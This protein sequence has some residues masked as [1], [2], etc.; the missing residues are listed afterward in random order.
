[1]PFW[2]MITSDFE[3]KQ[4]VI[5]VIIIRFDCNIINL[6]SGEANISLILARNFSVYEEI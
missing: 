5:K 4:K 6:I 2:H 3:I 1:M